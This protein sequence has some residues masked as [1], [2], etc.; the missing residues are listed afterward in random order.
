MFIEQIL[1]LLQTI[2]SDAILAMLKAPTAMVNGLLDLD[3][4]FLRR[5]CGIC[6]FSKYSLVEDSNPRRIMPIR[7]P[8]LSVEEQDDEGTRV[9]SLELRNAK[10]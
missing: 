9:D 6:D 7:F 1:T 4:D 8:T 5:Y 10:L 2:F 3:E